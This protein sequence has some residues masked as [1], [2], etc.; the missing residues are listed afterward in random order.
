MNNRVIPFSPPDITDLE[1]NAVVEV[2]KS[3][4]ITSGPKV[5]LLEEKLQ[6]YCQADHAVAL[7]SNSQ[8][9]DLILKVL[10][11]SGEAEILTT[12]YTYVATANAA[13]HRGIK[14]TFI[15]LKKDS[16]FMD[17]EKLYDAISDKTKVILTVDIGGVPMDYDVVKNILREKNRED[18]LLI[19]DSAHSI[20][21]AY[22]GAPVGTQFDFHVFSFHAVKNLTTAEG[23][24][25]TF[26][27]DRENLVQVFKYSSLN[28]QTKDALSKMKAGA[29]RY[30]ILTDGLKCNMTDIGAAIGLVQLDRYDKILGQRKKLSHIYHSILSEKEWALL[31]LLENDI[32][33]SSY[34]LYPLRI[35]GFTEEQRDRVIQELAEMGIATNVHYIPIPMFTYYKELGYDIQDY[36]NTYAQYANEITLPLYSILTSA[37]CEYVAENVIKAVEKHRK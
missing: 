32:M 27:G 37:D 24:A 35:Q 26:N 22:K 5:H 7:A 36:P 6:E 20:G 17:E 1:I 30:D 21:A 14:P 13:L 28:G 4:W 12:P 8:G 31:P 18:I 16:F 29:W 15:D 9:L 19:S 11:I 25:I 10:N 23:G 33:E 34:H 3:G 2:L